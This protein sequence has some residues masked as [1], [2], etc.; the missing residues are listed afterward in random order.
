M[1]EVVGLGAM[2]MDLVYQVER[3]LT[4]GEAP[5]ERYTPFPGGSAANT[6]YGLAKLGVRT[7]LV[8]AVGN[9]EEGRLLLE[10]L[11]AVAVDTEKIKVKGDSRTGTAFCLA[12]RRGRRAIYISPGANSL[13]TRQDID[14]GYINQ[15]KILHL[16]SFI[17]DKQFDIQKELVSSLAPSLKLSFA[18]GAI[19]ASKGIDGLAPLLKRTHI[20]FANQNEIRQLTGEEFRGGARQC[21]K[22]GCHI[23]AITLGKGVT[24]LK[25]RAKIA[26]CYITSE[27]KEFFIEA[28]RMDKKLIADTIGAG[29]AFAA[30]FLWGVLQGKELEECGY[31]G[32]I[33]ARF[34]I[35][36]A[37][38][39]AGLPSLPELRQCY[40]EVYN[41]PL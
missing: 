35:T 14:L 40:E 18:P 28:E 32:D 33:M 13:L 20:L 10:D 30:G 34:S 38:A 21:L 37:G 11:K 8:G 15:A 19:Y 39:R 23:V 41:R 22:Q 17:N 36:R 27:D 4:D 9:D 26:S 2:N 7:G 5:V 1:I 6:I 12:D 3:I 31:L 29:D 25:S 24:Y 16:S